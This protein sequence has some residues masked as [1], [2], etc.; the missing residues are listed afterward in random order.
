MKTKSRGRAWLL[1]L[2]APYVAVVWVGSYNKVEPELL[3]FPFFYWWQLVWV[4]LC[5]IIVA[6]VFAMTRA[7]K[8]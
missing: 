6:V 8:S 5:S 7:E 1:L 4:V 3:G 2:L